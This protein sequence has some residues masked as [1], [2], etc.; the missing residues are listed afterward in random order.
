MSI[1]AISVLKDNKLVLKS[2]ESST[3]DYARG[4]RS[5]VY[6]LWRDELDSYTFIDTLGF[7]VE[8]GMMRAWVEGAAS[9]GVGESELTP[10]EVTA[11]REMI[12]MQYLPIVDFANAIVANSKAKR[13]KLAPLYRRAD[14]WVNRY[15]EAR[16]RAMQMACGNRKL[17]WVVNPIKEHCPSCLALDG[18]VY[19]ASVWQQYDLRPRMRGLRCGGWACGCEFVETDEPVTHGFPPAL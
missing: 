3:R 19:R 17:K 6:G 4:I 12:A 2:I 16:N 13:G 14:L 7:A 8:R 9:C 5:L 1:I 10:E 15:G 18:R 11:R